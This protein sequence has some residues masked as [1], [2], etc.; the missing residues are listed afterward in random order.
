MPSAPQ[1]EYPSKRRRSGDYHDLSWLEEVRSKIWNNRELGLE[2]F[3]S[4]DVTRAHYTELKNRLESQHPNRGTPE[5]DAWNKDVLSIK[6]DVLGLTFPEETPSQHP[7]DNE[8]QVFDDD[9]PGESNEDSSGADDTDPGASNEHGAEIGDDDLE[10]SNENDAEFNDDDQVS[11]SENDAEFD[12]DRLEASN[13]GGDI[14]SFFPS[15]LRF[16][17]LSPLDLKEEVPDRLPLP[18]FLR[19]E[20]DD[21]SALIK[22]LPRRKQGSVIVSGQPGTGKILV[23]VSHR[24]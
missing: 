6:L 16:L 14:N 9:D 17:D 7:D 3:R 5:Y 22:T 19:Q 24:I 11:S 18:L 15:T 10:P 23:S 4:V 13:K 21:I 12:Y 2:L 8:D 1:N 20:Y